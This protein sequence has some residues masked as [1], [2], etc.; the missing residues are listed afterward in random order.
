MK[1]E[2]RYE[3]ISKDGK[4]FTDWFTCFEGNIKQCNDW[5]NKQPKEIMKNKYEYRVI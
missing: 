3:F 5:I 2:E 4:K 1:V